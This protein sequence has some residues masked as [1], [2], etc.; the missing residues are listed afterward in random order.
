MENDG[1]IYNPNATG[2]LVWGPQFTRLVSCVLFP[3]VSS[4]FL[5]ASGVLRGTLERCGG[6]G[7]V[8]EMGPCSCV[9]LGARVRCDECHSAGQ[10]WSERVNWTHR[11]GQAHETQRFDQT[12]VQMLLGR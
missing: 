6:G 3:T 8:M 1:S 9:S 2:A 4:T 5:P 11:P 12:P 10:P 7:W